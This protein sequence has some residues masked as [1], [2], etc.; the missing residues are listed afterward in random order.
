MGEV[1]TFGEVMAMFV[2]VD[3]GPLDEVNG[4]GFRLAGAEMNVAVGLARLGHRV[5]Y[6]GAVGDDPFGRR[7]RR[8]L[9]AEGIDTSGL[10]TD[11][12]AP[13]G[14]Q[15]KNRVPAGDP[16]VVYFRRDSAASQLTW[17]P[18]AAEVIG[19]AGHLHLTGIFP[20]LSPR[21]LEFALRA[22]R[23]AKRAAATVS[24]DPN[25]RP[26]LWPD[27]GEM[28]ETVNRFAALADWVLPGLAEGELLTG[29]ASPRGIADFYL[30][31]GA[32]EVVIKL[33]ADGAVFHNRHGA[34]SEPAFPARVVDTVGAGDG[35]A[36]GWISGRLDGLDDRAALRRACVVGA[37]ATTSEGDKDGL[38]TKAELR[39]LHEHV[40]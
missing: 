13:T 25:I 34:I 21:T 17:S 5:R 7:A 37:L 4:F 12:R 29:R 3:Q 32:A 14:F 23:T 31:R 26:V 2:A 19:R 24:F 27:A 10:L 30:E 11:P 15:L 18:A 6:L 38:P 1:V 9:S 40:A 28:V 22:V 36:A 33:G 35:F 39:E 8:E 20:A 16:S